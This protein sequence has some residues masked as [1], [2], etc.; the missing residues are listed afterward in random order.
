ML[1]SSGGIIEI[2]GKPTATV[3]DE[4]LTTA[5]KDRL[6]AIC[7]KWLDPPFIPRTFRVFRTSAT[8]CRLLCRVF[9]AREIHTVEGKVFIVKAGVCEVA[10]SHEIEALASA[11]LARR[12]G[13][14]FENTLDQIAEQS[15]LLSRLLYAIPLVMRNEPKLVEGLPTSI[16]VIR[17]PRTNDKS[18][19]VHD[20]IQELED[21]Q[22]EIYPFGNPNGNCTILA[23]GHPRL[24]RYKKHYSRY[25]TFRGQVGPD[26]LEQ[27]SWPIIG[28]PTLA[29]Q[30]S[31][32]VSLVE[33]GVLI[34]DAP[35]LLV[36]LKDAWL[37]DIL[38][39]LAWIKSSFFIWFCA[40]CIGE[41]NPFFA[42]QFC[43]SRILIPDRREATLIAKLG[44]ITKQ[45]VAKECEFMDEV[46]RA[47]KKGDLDDSYREKLRTRHNAAANAQCLSIDKEIYSYLEVSEEL[48]QSIG[49][50]LQDLDMTDFGLLQ[51]T[52]DK[53]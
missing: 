42:L 5:T 40:V 36:D 4:A 12:Y 29:V 1:N 13:K 38:G 22:E 7:E 24:P 46:N 8:S 16:K 33:P 11:K 45:L 15:K 27:H 48:Q 19:E 26:V 14:R 51:E 44:A 41:E 34:C 30:A 53:D 6:T 18:S 20:F 32:S 37:S 25:T 31:G 49:R 43:S 35:I 2:D 17:P 47:K 28:S 21:K 10:K 23:A 50:T 52:E 9:P 39:L 3:S